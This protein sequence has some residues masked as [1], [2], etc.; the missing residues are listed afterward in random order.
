MGRP[1]LPRHPSLEQYRK[2]AKNLV[3]N[4]NS[5]DPEAMLRIRQYHPRFGRL[6]D[7][8]LPVAAFAL[9]DAQWIIAR[10]HGFESW[11]KFA[12]HIAGLTLDGSAASIEKTSKAA[13]VAIQLE[14]RTAEIHKCAFTRDGRNA[15]TAAEGN[16]VQVWD[17]ET[18]R[19]LCTFGD[20]TVG[21]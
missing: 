10:E 19:C 3:K 14:I 2:Q 8:E 17:L 15:L 11:P 6:S 21:T 5:D 1:P 12:K 13:I 20:N 18:G 4:Y 9:A 7:S 16:P